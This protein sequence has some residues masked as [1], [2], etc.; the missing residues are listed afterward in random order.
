MSESLLLFRLNILS[1]LCLTL[2]LVVLI[3][4]YGTM[5]AAIALLVSSIITN[6]YALLL[7]HRL[8]APNWHRAG[9]TL[10]V[11]ITA[12]LFPLLLGIYLLRFPILNRPLGFL[13]LVVLMGCIF[14]GIIMSVG[15][16]L[17]KVLMVHY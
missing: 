5:G 17:K 16:S 10:T 4:T 13:V 3:P 7:I 14:G 15:L 1:L 8:V 12:L 11:I 6:S 2:L 9:E